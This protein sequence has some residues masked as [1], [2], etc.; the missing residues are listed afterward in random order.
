M[1]DDDVTETPATETPVA[2]PPPGVDPAAFAQMQASIAALNDTVNAIAGHMQRPAQTVSTPSG[3][4]LNVTPQLRQFLRAKGLSDADIDTNAPLI[5]PFAEAF[6]GEL[7]GYVNGTVGG[8]NDRLTRA[9]MEADDVTYKHARLL[10]SEINTILKNAEK[11]GQ[12]VSREAA[13]HT[14]VST[15]IDKIVEAETKQRS[16]GRGADAAAMQGVGHRTASS[17]AARNRQDTTAASA[18]DLAAMTHEQRL[19]YYEKVSG[20]PIQ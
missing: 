15:N 2:T 16:E 18:A 10:R 9:E 1:A 6:A 7:V 8:V 12:P 19:A 17:G 14:A 4:S 20:N 13:Y 3:G 11:S 5:L